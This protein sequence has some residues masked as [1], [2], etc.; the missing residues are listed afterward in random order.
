M[1]S[2]G[3][4]QGEVGGEVGEGERSSVLLS[5]R[6][7]AETSPRFERVQAKNRQIALVILTAANSRLSSSPRSIAIRQRPTQ[8]QYARRNQI[9]AAQGT[10]LI[11]NEPGSQP[12]A[13]MAERAIRVVRKVGKRLRWRT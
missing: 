1:K 12:E 5:S 2:G 8:K 13:L 7:Q 3:G 9:Q 4:E 6:L 11:Y 10:G